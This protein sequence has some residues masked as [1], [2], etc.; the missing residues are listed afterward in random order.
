MYLCSYLHTSLENYLDY[1]IL[2][3][4]GLGI[5]HS[6]NL[7]QLSLKYLNS[8]TELP[9]DSVAQ[10]VRAWQAICEVTS[11]SLSHCLFFPSLLSRLY[12]TPFS[13]TVWL[14]L[15]LRSVKSKVSSRGQTTEEEPGYKASAPFNLRICP[16][17]LYYCSLTPEALWQLSVHV[18][19]T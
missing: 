3:I 19:D 12:F 11:P 4:L 16:Q 9:G 15:R 13:L 2:D 5:R 8:A 18:C 10:L 17:Q 6:G 14:W 1:H 7:W